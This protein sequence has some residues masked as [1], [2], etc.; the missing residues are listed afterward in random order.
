MRK[1]AHVRTFLGPITPGLS[2]F[3]ENSNSRLLEL[4][5]EARLWFCCFRAQILGEEVIDIK[6]VG[7]R[8]DV[9]ELHVAL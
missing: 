3:V 7:S 1:K 6:K 5:F 8:D 9:F 4:T 2:T